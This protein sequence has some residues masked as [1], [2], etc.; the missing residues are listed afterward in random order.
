MK[1]RILSVILM[2]TLFAS[3]M[4]HVFAEGVDG[5]VVLNP[6]NAS[7]FNH[8]EFEGWGTSMGWWGNRI[9]HSD[10]MA[11]QAA[12]LFYGEDGLGLDIVRYNVGGGDDPT[13]NHITRSDSKLP[14]FAVPELDTDGKPVK[15]VDGN[16][17]YTYDWTADHDQMNVLQRIKEIN[18]EVHIE[19]YTN[20]PPW[21]MTNSGCSGGGVDAGENL[22][23]AN[24][25]QFAKFVADVAE[26]FS[27][28]GL[29]F[30]SYSPMN[31]PSTQK[32]YWG[33]MSPKQEG[34]HVAPGE[35]QSGIINTL[36]NELSA[37]NFYLPV[38]G[39]DETNIDYTIT[40]YNALNDEAKAN[41]ARIDTHTYEGSKRAQL[42]QTAMDANMNLWMSEVDGSWDEFGLAD[43]IIAD[44]NGM[45]AS[46]WV[47]WDIVDFHKDS[48]FVNSEGNKTEANASMNP[49]GKMWGMAMGNHDTEEIELSQKY[50]GYGQ[51][52]RYIHPGM[53]II[54]SESNTLAAYDKTTGEIVIVAVNSG[55][56]AKNIKFDLRDFQRTGTKARPVRTSG[57]YA[58]GEHWAELAPIEITDKQFTAELKADSITTFVIDDPVVTS[59]GVNEEGMSYE[60]STPSA[61]LGY[62]KWFAVYDK[63]GMLKAVRCNKDSGNAK[64]DF[65]DCTF[66][67][68]VWDG[69]NPVCE[70]ITETGKREAV[71]YMH[72]NGY[73]TVIE[74][75]E[76][77]F[78]LVSDISLIDSVTWS[79]SDDEAA[80]IKSQ[81]SA[82]A[83]CTVAAK[84]G[85]SFTLRATHESGAYAEMDIKALAAD[86]WI[87]ITNKKSGL[88]LETKSKGIASGTQLVQWANRDLDT[89]AWKLTPTTDGHY[90]IINKNADMLLV[91]NSEQKPVIS[92]DAA[93]DDNS[94]KWDLINH[95]GYYE[96]KNVAA[97]KSLDVS[98][99]STANGGSV[100]LYAFGNG[101]NE[102][103][104][105]GEAAE[106]LEHVVP[107]VVDYSK[108]Y[109]GTDYTFV[110]N[111]DAATND[112]NEG[113]AKGFVISGEAALTSDGAGEA[114]L[115]VQKNYSNK[116]DVAQSG[117]AALETPITCEEGQIINMS[118]DLYCSNSG[119]T[120]DFG[121]YDGETELIKMLYSNWDDYNMTVA[122]NTTTETG[123][124]KPYLR[125][126]VNDKTE[127]QLIAN[128]AHIEIYY[129]PSTGAIKLTMK[130]NTNSS[131]LK[132]YE[133]SVAAGTGISKLSFNA[134]Y[135]TWSKPM[136]VDN[137]ITNIISAK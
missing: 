89:A 54:E 78:S 134:N 109:E 112:F 14:C 76:Y 102:L 48:N 36:C 12:E 50:Y 97:E 115:G 5:T 131:A 75:V 9:G 79:V 3:L 91:S 113:D 88:G 52:T 26:H 62:N 120:A 119:G 83:T 69:M 51:F 80:E 106:N 29:A 27:D 107:E 126:N 87:T 124:A 28:I 60:Y 25:A 92:S 35:H 58:T 125:N 45:N 122:G 59:F 32:K 22:D 21:F 103:W 18:P 37:R 110:K 53:T 24:Y 84:K 2:L 104:S 15:D 55:N 128:G 135:T 129:K 93:A 68:I 49:D 86:Q 56:T 42:K 16:Y 77:N 6:A 8:G 72:V 10:K 133:G 132:T 41:L 43:R 17:V 74:N 130:N 19:G 118:F 67:L 95:G 30:D 46:A 64:G 81:N 123:Q 31:E 44:L 73:D 47:L 7:P 111:V 63:N 114:V 94:A 23:S 108:K 105:L 39:L 11:Q 40:S 117:S 65:T 127:N 98:G 57:S 100:I 1:K 13:H 137:L 70:P 85:G 96:I 71:S 136:F 61:M 116:P 34:N 82:E 33:S 101:D 38:V 90:N 66:K 20:S 99:Q 121:I 4:P